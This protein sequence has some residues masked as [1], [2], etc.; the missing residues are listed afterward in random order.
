MTALGSTLDTT[1]RITMYPTLPPPPAAT[2]MPTMASVPSNPLVPELAQRR[3]AVA[4]RVREANHK[5][6]ARPRHR[7][8]VLVADVMAAIG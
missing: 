3:I 2:V 1:A 4:S 8:A 7:R 6:R 5:A